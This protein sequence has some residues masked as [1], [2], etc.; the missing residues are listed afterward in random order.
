[1]LPKIFCEWHQGDVTAKDL[2][3]EYFI[4][5]GTPQNN[6]VCSLLVYSKLW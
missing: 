1:M 2:S 3:L 4:L 6:V 5:H